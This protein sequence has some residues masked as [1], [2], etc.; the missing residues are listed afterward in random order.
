MTKKKQEDNR[1][2]AY[3]VIVSYCCMFISWLMGSVGAEIFFA[4]IA[5]TNT[6]G[7]YHE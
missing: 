4:T 5:I 1:L 3:A 6:I 7:Y 2:I